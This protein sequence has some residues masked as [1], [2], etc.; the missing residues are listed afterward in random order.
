MASEIFINLYKTIVENLKQFSLKLRCFENLPN[1]W[2]VEFTIH[3]I[4]A[5]SQISIRWIKK[6]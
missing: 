2:F 5:I 6:W 3:F 4:E 1:P